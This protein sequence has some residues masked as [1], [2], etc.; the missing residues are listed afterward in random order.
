MASLQGNGARAL[1]L[2]RAFRDELIAAYFAEKIGGQAAVNSRRHEAELRAELTASLFGIKSEREGAATGAVSAERWI[3]RFLHRLSLV[4]GLL[5]VVLYMLWWLMSVSVGVVTAWHPGWSITE[6]IVA[7]IVV[8]AAIKTFDEMLEQTFFA[9]RQS[10]WADRLVAAAAIIGIAY[11]LAQFA[12]WD[13]IVS[14]VQSVFSKWSIEWVT[15][16]GLF[17]GAIVAI[18]FLNVGRI[19]YWVLLNV[20]RFTFWFITG[21]AFK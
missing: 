10:D 20:W 12:N 11:Y 16:K 13:R 7:I 5:L 21:R 6:W 8:S 19:A 15:V 3:E 2:F 1:F 17:I 18:I 14:Y 9:W 4:V